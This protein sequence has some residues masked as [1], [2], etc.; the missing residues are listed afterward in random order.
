MLSN[1][2]P[3]VSL[4]SVPLRVAELPLF[5][6]LD[7][8]YN[9]FYQNHAMHGDRM[10]L[11]PQ[12]WLQGEVLPGISFSGRSGFRETLF[13]VDKTVPGGP[14]E[15]YIPR[16][17]F[18][19]Q[20]SLSGN[21]ARDYGRE[22][23]S[24][25]YYRHVVRPEVF[26]WNMPRYNPRRYPDFDPFDMGWVAQVN[27]NLPVRPGD[28]PLGG[29]NALTYGISNTVLARGQTSQGQATVRDVLWLRLSQSAF[30]NKTSMGL[31]GTSIRHHPFSDFWG[32]MEFYPFRQLTLGANA[33]V[34]PYQEGFERADFKVTLLDAQRQNYINVNYV[35]VK[36]FAKQINV[37][38][39]LNLFR[40]VKTWL[41]FGHTFETERK[42]EQRYGVVFQQ[43]CW[44]VS[45]TYTE[46]PDDKRVGV[47][48]FIPGLSEKLKRSAVR[49]PEEGRGREGPDLY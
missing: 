36:N 3:G 12:M 20:V 32:E 19:S 27:R 40:S 14:P 35:Y 17:L 33:G 5:V 16:Q 29:V 42:L 49:F 22:G 43:Q 47:I 25:D 37:E 4:Y 9:Y 7:S 18:D 10:D 39:Y 38:T 34:S 8:S 13:R 15:K 6:G 21:F 45:L 11:H 24:Q 28:D 26:Y 46:R 44:G 2:I 41:T 23:G 31:D 30:F 48:V 1:R